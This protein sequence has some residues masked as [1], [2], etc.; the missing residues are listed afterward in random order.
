MPKRRNLSVR[1]RIIGRS[2]FIYPPKPE[3]DTNVEVIVD[4][5]PIHCRGR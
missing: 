4:C 5:A 2:R 1:P 3:G